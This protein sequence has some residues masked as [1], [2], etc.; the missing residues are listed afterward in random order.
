MPRAR[1]DRDAAGDRRA[2]AR[3][4][5]PLI[6]APGAGVRP[7]GPGAAGG[8]VAMASV[9]TSWIAAA[10]L[11]V[12]VAGTVTYLAVDAAD[13]PAASAGVASP[14]ASGRSPAT[15]RVTR[16]RQPTSETADAPPAA[17]SGAD[18]AAA[19]TTAVL[20]PQPEGVV[21]AVSGVVVDR[22]T[23]RALAG[24]R[25]L[26]CHVAD[27]AVEASWQGDTTN[28]QGRFECSFGEETD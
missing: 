10:A 9:K 14:E 5:A 16:T 15:V 21:R 26:F 2:W 23:G 24:A 7:R 19:T 17:A 11:L 8:G 28:E 27:E 1:R 18:D 6:V 12:A 20:P 3:A 25:V 22:A 13:E 4:L